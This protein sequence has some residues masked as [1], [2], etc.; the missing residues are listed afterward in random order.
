MSL[1][2]IIRNLSIFFSLILVLIIGL[3]F[4]ILNLDPN[5]YREQITDLAAQQG[6]DLRID[7]DMGWKIYPEL[8]LEI[9]QIQVATDRPEANYAADIERVELLVELWPLIKREF[10][11]RGLNLE[12]ANIQLSQKSENLAV[13]TPATGQPEAIAAGSQPANPPAAQTQNSGGIPIIVAERMQIS[14]S[15]FVVLDANGEES[16]AIQGIEILVENLNLNG[17]QT[18]VQGSVAEV[19]SSGSQVV[20]PLDFGLFLNITPDNLYAQINE[21][22]VEVQL[23]DSSLPMG[24]TGDIDLS[25]ANQQF[26]VVGLRLQSGAN[27]TV[28]V[29]LEGQLSELGYQ[30]DLDILLSNP[31]ALLSQLQVE[32]PDMPETSLQRIGLQSSLQGTPNTIALGGL[33]WQLDQRNFQGEMRLGWGDLSNLVLRG[34]LDQLNLDSYSSSTEIEEGEDSTSEQA[35][36][37][38]PVLPFNRSDI[39]LEISSLQIAE[40]PMRRVHLVVNSNTRQL[41]LQELSGETFGGN[42]NAAAS[43]QLAGGLPHQFDVQ[44]NSVAIDQFLATRMEE[45][46]FAGIVTMQLT[47]LATGTEV[48]ELRQT[49]EADGRLQATGLVFRGQDIEQ[50]ICDISDRLERRSLQSSYADWGESTSFEDLNATLRIENGE[51]RLQ[52]LRTGVG[53][54]AVTGQ[55]DY[56]LEQQDYEM[57]LVTRVE[58]ELTS[59]DGCAVHSSLR[60]REIPL[61]CSGNTGEPGSLSC[62]IPQEFTRSLI[63]GAVTRGLSNQ[64]LGDDASE[65]EQSNPRNLLEGLLRRSLGQ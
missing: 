56:G 41:R 61:R 27:L 51:A 53:N 14:N 47:G 17:D 7:G 11:L 30:G 38:I 21:L 65:E 24:L 57:N 9:S 8:S 25:L 16:L 52:S 63:T 44:V 26:S 40:V 59:V 49:L 15:G 2:R 54:I 37:F 28:T 42:F 20:A 60:D 48:T 4:F 3:V 33:R 31:R 64:L 22:T 12:G 55:G 35:G 1:R 46:P 6:V 43:L 39:D 45:V 19:R 5:Q 10:R 58:G 18:S 34:Q 23:E 62:G 29:N 32:I 36:P 50:V 13:V